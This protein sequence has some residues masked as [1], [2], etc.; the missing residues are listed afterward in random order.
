LGS[1]SRTEAV[2]SEKAY[3]R[4]FGSPG[5]ALPPRNFTPCGVEHSGDERVAL[6]SAGRALVGL[7]GFSEDQE[8]K[9]APHWFDAPGKPFRRR[10][11]VPFRTA[12]QRPSPLTSPLSTSR[13]PSG[14]VP[15]GRRRSSMDRLHPPRL[16]APS[17][18]AESRIRST[19]A[20]QTRHLPSSAFL[21]LST[22]C[23]PRRLPGFFHPGSAPGVLGLQG[24]PPRPGGPSLSRGRLLSCRS[25]PI[26]ARR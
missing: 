12:G 6:A 16:P 4:S 8:R 1:N 17:A 22:V 5:S 21:T 26:F 14:R 18:Q 19:R 9:V 11:G 3:D 15:K 2:W 25:G 10:S 23:T 13:A 24:V 20:C 7:R